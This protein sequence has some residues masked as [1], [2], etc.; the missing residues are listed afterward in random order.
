[1]SFFKQLFCRHEGKLKHV[2]DVYG[3]GIT[4]LPRNNRSVWECPK[5]GKFIYKEYLG[6]DLIYIPDTDMGNVSDGYH[7]FN[8]LYDHRAK[9]F[10]TI[11][12]DHKDL[13][14]KSLYHEDGSMYDGMFIV[15]IMTPLG[16][17]TYH[18][19]L[20]PYWY[21]F[22]VEELMRAPKWDGHTPTDAI[23]RILT[24]K[25]LKKEN[26]PAISDGSSY[27]LT[28][29][30]HEVTL[31]EC[32]VGLFEYDGTLGMKTE[33]CTEGKDGY[34]IDAYI[35][36]SGERFCISNDARVKPCGVWVAE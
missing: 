31:A 32:P 27:F 15:G 23:S 16:M 17:A 36:D 20:N 35:V 8:E 2:L 18:Y 21:L 3:D 13:A 19:D 10:A 25:W 12:N 30:D 6:K 14:W 9:L 24:L 11:C 22:D 7:T 28:P 34:K 33:Y 26:K 29:E 4:S 5:C 1:M